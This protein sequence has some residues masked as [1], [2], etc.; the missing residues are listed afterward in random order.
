MKNTTLSRNWFQNN[1]KLW[2]KNICFSESGD[3]MDN[4]KDTFEIHFCQNCSKIF[5]TW[6]LFIYHRQRF[7]GMKKQQVNLRPIFRGYHAHHQSFR[8]RLSFQI[9]DTL[10][11][12]K[13]QLH[14]RGK[15]Q[16][17]GPMISSAWHSLKIALHH[18][19]MS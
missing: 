15:F 13:D 6:I 3:W 5:T 11:H 19:E 7:P 17:L 2:C 18:Q 1:R 10:V 9:V 8:S 14:G 4:W 16:I 12:T